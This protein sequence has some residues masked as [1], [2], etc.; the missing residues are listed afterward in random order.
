MS[1]CIFQADGRFTCKRSQAQ[2]TNKN[3]VEH[4]G[5]VDISPL[6]W[7]DKMVQYRPV[8]IDNSQQKYICKGNQEVGS[9]ENNGVC[10]THNQRLQIARGILPYST[11]YDGF[12][13][14]N[15]RVNWTNNVGNKRTVRVTEDRAICRAKVNGQYDAGYTSF[16]KDANQKIIVGN[17]CYLPNKTLSRDGLEYLVFK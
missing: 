3:I 15:N 5:N 9:T 17:T 11:L 2:N 14:Q 6:L 8:S 16:A 12:N 7:S 1:S 4:F 10:R 13:Y